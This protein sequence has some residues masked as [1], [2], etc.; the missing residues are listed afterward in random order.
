MTS[1]FLSCYNWPIIKQVGW[2]LGQVMGLLYNLF[3]YIGIANIGLCIIVFTIVIKML[4]LP[5]TLKQ[6][7]FTKLSAIMNPEIQAVQKKYKN[8]KD[9]DSMMKMNK[10]I[11][12]IYEKYGTSQTGGCLQLLIQMPIILALYGVISNI[13]QYVEDVDIM[14]KAASTQVIESADYFHDINELKEIYINTIPEDAESDDES[15]E[16]ANKMIKGKDI[17]DFLDKYYTT[18]DKVFNKESSSKAI[19]DDFVT[20]SVS[21]SDLWNQIYSSYDDADDIIRKLNTLSAEDWETLLT[22][23]DDKGNLVNEDKIELIEKY[24]KFDSTQWDK[25]KEN[26][27][28][29]RESVKDAEKDIESVYSFAGINLSISPSA[30]VWW[31]LLIPILSALSQWLSMKIS[32]TNQPQTATDNP[33]GSSMKAMTYTMPI[34][35]A[36]FCYSL[37]AG[38]GLYWVISAV[39]QCIQQLAI[40]KHFSGMDVEDLIKANLDKVN[41]KRE[42]QGLPPKTISTAATVNVRNIKAKED[43]IIDMEEVNTEDN[44]GKKKGSLASKAGMA[45]KYN[46]K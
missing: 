7:R 27:K 1:V 44:N 18:E 35:S 4:M 15:D 17:E 12:A 2:V 9:Q 34:M 24:S 37:P 20:V 10:E 33:M 16:N 28:S 21:N 6:Q 14:Y 13:P 26:L 30:G 36:V 40:N 38:L 45:S 22:K 23:E 39:V 32:S 3:N 46:K 8:K 42:R 31:A 19:K 41:K 5:M 25:L 43:K 11:S 29:D